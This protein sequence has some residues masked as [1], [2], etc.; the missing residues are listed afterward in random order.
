M[1]S[2]EFNKIV[3]FLFFAA[4]LSS[5][6]TFKSGLNGK[7]EGQATKNYKAEKVNVLFVF[8]HYQQTKG[9]DAVPK[10]DYRP[11]D[12]FEEIFADAMNE[13][14]NID[15]YSAFTDMA[16]D[17]NNSKRRRLKDSLMHCNDYI[18]KIRIQS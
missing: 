14:S 17:V 1:N 5:C 10:I 4:L 11:V 8:S 9:L 7:F 2:K 6:A 3:F 13:L 16:G 15:F 12:G 18:I